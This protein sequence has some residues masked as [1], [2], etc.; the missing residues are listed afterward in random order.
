MT[1]QIVWTK[2]DIKSHLDDFRDLYKDRPIKNNDGGMKSPHMF[3]AW[4][5]IKK[6][7]PKYIIESGVWKGLGTWFFEQASPASQIICLDPNPQNRVYTSSRSIYSTADFSQIN[8]ASVLE[9]CETLVFID[10]HQNALE[11][12]QQCRRNRFKRIIFED[13]YPFDQGDCYSIKKILSGKDYLID[14][15]GEKVY[16]KANQQDKEIVESIVDIYQEM[17]PI[18]KSEFTRW[19]NLWDYE[20]PEPILTQ[21]ELENYKDFKDEILDYTWI[22]YIEL[23]DL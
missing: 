11:R 21:N 14:K 8:W 23:A 4:Y 12:I 7:Q 20:T 22:C 13:N 1:N 19:N 15:S 3:P 16:Y 2:S 9:T 6:L 10:D 18:A 5:I 17:P